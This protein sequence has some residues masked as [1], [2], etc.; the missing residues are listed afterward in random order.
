LDPTLDRFEHPDR[1]PACAGLRRRPFKKGN[2]DYAR[3][4]KDQIKITDSE[5]GKIWD[6]SRCEDCGHIFADPAPKPEFIFGL[7]R[8]VEDPAY[9]V[10]AEGRSQ[11]F[12]GIL[13]TLD[14]LQPERGTLFD[15]GAA[16]GI[17]LEAARGRGWT[18]D[19]VEASDWAAE[20]ARRSRNLPLR[21]GFFEETDV[22]PGSCR[23]V[24]MVDFIEHTPRPRDAAAK[25]YD[26]LAPQGVLCLVTPDIHSFAAR[27]AGRRWWHLR[28]GHLAYFSKKSLAALLGDAGFTII[29]RKRYAWTFS[30]HYLLTR[31]K[32]F[33]FLVRGRRAA[34][35]F[36]KI[37]I[38]LALGDS[39]E[40]YARKDPRT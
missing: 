19:G 4:D 20:R 12:R 28:P 22:A 30:A 24:T 13:K 15:V 31:F 34:L 2:F 1:C 3:L 33:R 27:L 16:T 6:L 36:K 11:N 17:L 25:A 21:R 29:R 9:D 37:P 38:K 5:Y 10:E 14:T 23:V 35:I 18:P 32:A 26:I 7:Y 39:F 40:I 8:Q